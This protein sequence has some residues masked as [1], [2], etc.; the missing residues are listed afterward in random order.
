VSSGDSFFTDGVAYERL[1]GRWSRRVGEIFL[2]WIGVPNE[3]RWL[4]VGCGTGAFTEELIKHRSPKSVVAIDPSAEQI[5]FARSRPGLENVE[6]HIGD[7]R[8]LPFADDSFD[9]AVMA[10]VIH[11]VPEPA[12]AVAEMARVVRPGGLAASYV[13]DYSVGGSPTA[14]VTA[15]VKALGLEA[16]PPPSANATS[17]PALRELWRAA[18]LEDIETRVITI[19]VGHASFDAFWESISA[20][21]GPTGKV[22]ADM[23]PASRERLRSL[24]HEQVA[25]QADG[26]VVYEASANAIKGRARA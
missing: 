15:A 22:I 4:D 11:F 10:L 12:E 21:V 19:P 16:P 6:F 18:G 24:M 17:M 7:A 23:P 14:P 26:R 8:S 25:I 3:L 9:I 20:P 2:D 13:W 5:A 1:M